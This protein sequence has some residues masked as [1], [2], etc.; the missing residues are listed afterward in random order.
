MLDKK[1]HLSS[2]KFTTDSLS[3]TSFV[4]VPCSNSFAALCPETLPGFVQNSQPAILS[5]SKTTDQIIHTFDLGNEKPMTITALISGS[6]NAN[7]MIDSGASSSFIDEVFLRENH[8]IPRKKRHPETVRVVDGR[9]SSSGK[10]THEIDLT[11]QIDTHIEV[12]TF[13]VTRIARYNIILGKSWLSNHDPEIKWS[14]NIISFTSVFCRDHCLNTLHEHPV[15]APLSLLSTSGHPVLRMTGSQ[16]TVDVA[17]RLISTLLKPK[18]SS[19]EEDNELRQRIPLQFHEFLSVFSSRKA[20]IL[21]PHRYI[22][23]EIPID[24]Q[25]KLVLG[26]EKT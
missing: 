7:T 17:P 10:I 18:V 26:P 23:H 13:Q 5:T 16:R 22:D 14:S 4:A 12:L 15:I 9:Q 3:V 19:V 1:R 11:L 20:E 2:R 21:P 25:K 8:L 24:K 6:I